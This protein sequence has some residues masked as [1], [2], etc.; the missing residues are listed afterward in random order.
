M[1]GV[2]TSPANVTVSGGN[3]ALQLS[4][5]SV[6]ALINTN[7]SDSGL[8]PGFQLTYGYTEARIYFPGSGA[9]IYNW[10]AFWTDGQ[11]WPDTGE[12]DIAEGL[13]GLTANYHGG[14]GDS[15]ISN[16]PDP[17]PG[18]WSNGWHVYGVDREPG[19]IKIYWDGVLI[20]TVSTADNGALQYLIFNVGS[21]SNNVTGSPGAMLVD[22][23]TSWVSQLTSPTFSVTPGNG[24]LTI[25]AFGAISNAVSYSAQLYQSDGVTAVGGPVTVT[26]SGYTFSSLSGNTT[27]KVGLT[28][29]GNNAYGA[30]IQANVKPYANSAQTQVSGTTTGSQLTTPSFTVTAGN[31]TIVL[32]AFSAVPNASSYTAWVYDAT[33]TTLIQGP[34]TVTITGTTFTGLTNGT[35][36]TVRL[37]AIGDGVTYTNSAVA[38]QSTT[39]SAGGGGGGVLYQPKSPVPSVLLISFEN[40]GVSDIVGQSGAAPYINN[41]LL[42]NFP[43]EEYWSVG[44]Y[45]ACNYVMMVSGINVHD[46]NGAYQFGATNP[47]YNSTIVGDSQVNLDSIASGA[48]RGIVGATIFDQL[49]AMG[50]KWT[51][52]VQSS[53]APA[54]YRLPQNYFPHISSLPGATVNRDADSVAGNGA[55]GNLISDL[56]SGSPPQFMFYTPNNNYNGH[57]TNLT[58]SDTWLSTL[59][60][61]IQAT[62]WYK[63]GGTIII[64]WDEQDAYGGDS[65]TGLGGICV[66]IIVSLAAHNTVKPGLKGSSTGVF[67][68]LEAGFYGSIQ[69]TYGFPRTHDARFTATGN[70]GTALLPGTP[71]IDKPQFQWIM[72]APFD[73]TSTT[74]KGTINDANHQMWNGSAQPAPK[75]FAMDYWQ[76]GG[77]SQSNTITSAVH[78]L[79]GTAIAVMNIGEYE[80]ARADM[81]SWTVSSPWVGTLTDPITGNHYIDIRTSGGYYTSTI[82]PLMQARFS[83]AKNAGFDMV[84]GYGMDAYINGGGFSITAAQEAAY[85]QDCVTYCHSIGIG[86]A[87]MNAFELGSALAPVCDAAITENGWYSGKIYGGT[88]GAYLRQGKPIWNVEYTGNMSRATFNS[89]AGSSVPTG[90]QTYY[91]AAA[92]DGSYY[93]TTR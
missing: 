88:I 9:T 17:Q 89:F 41:T 6:G 43:Y 56:N 47:N 12:I 22:Y 36:Y 24:S 62:T 52:Y 83:N 4:S 5:S 28:A 30:S 37:Q 87:Q 68:S 66:A 21:G 53:P 48:D 35:T 81:A 80:A 46:A 58:Y 60:P 26:T 63:N 67:P 13:G 45:S 77:P 64:W 34:T 2:T 23:V 84:G 15:G 31:T 19:Q 73:S 16:G 82:K 11:S 18:T 39:P 20:R 61:N 93:V 27:Y 65:T 75:V 86:F 54:S 40:Y 57:D 38:T 42:A 3:L 76:N 14:P 78:A 51:A 44:H 7:P 72:S 85:I 79:P 90:I 25:N 50:M 70:F 49:S 8:S 32:N 92:R 1:N 91:M 71:A 10:P 33:N 55:G 69:D 74:H 29:V 59:I